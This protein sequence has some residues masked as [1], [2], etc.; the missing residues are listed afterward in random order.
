MI[1]DGRPYIESQTESMHGSFVAGEGI[2]LRACAAR[3]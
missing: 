1:G 2:G 3:R